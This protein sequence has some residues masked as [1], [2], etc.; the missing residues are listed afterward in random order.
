[1]AGSLCRD[2]P[3]YQALAATDAVDS[4]FACARLPTCA[5]GDSMFVL[6]VKKMPPPW[7]LC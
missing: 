7:K 3:H 6:A 2:R 1:M 4:K 5:L